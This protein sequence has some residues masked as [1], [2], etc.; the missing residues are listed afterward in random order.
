MVLRMPEV[1]KKREIPIAP[2]DRIM[3]Q[4][5]AERVSEEAAR[6]L[7]DFL[8][9]FAREISREA[10]ELAQ[11]ANRKTVTKEDV[12]FALKRFYRYFQTV[13]TTT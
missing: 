9:K 5:G 10:F 11:H 13:L 2:I 6:L 8:E 4:E 7:R 1:G 3:H 12:E